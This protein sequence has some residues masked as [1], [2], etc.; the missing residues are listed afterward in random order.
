MNAEAKILNKILANRIRQHNKKIIDHDQVGFIPG[1]QGWFNIC[2]SIYII[3][4]ITISKD[5]N[6]MVL[7]I[8]SEKTFDKIQ[9][10]FIKKALNKLGIEG[11]FLN[12]I[13]AIHE[14]PRA[15][16]ILNGEQLKPFPL[17][18]GIRQG[19]P[20]FPTPIQ[21]SF[22]FLARARRQN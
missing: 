1:M 20:T 4:H 12:V 14:K 17:K 18:S 10:A 5:K 19:C 2:K 13:N 21:Y 9:Y 6:H 8:D 16:I 11:M 15:N 7:S 3:Q 22:E